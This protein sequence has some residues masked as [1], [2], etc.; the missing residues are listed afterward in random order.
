ML[1]LLGTLVGAAF[2]AGSV[3]LAILVDRQEGA[4]SGQ[5]AGSGPPASAGH[6]LRLLPGT[7]Q[8]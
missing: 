7:D 2:L 6:R 3:A 4:G 1:E 5:H 8:G